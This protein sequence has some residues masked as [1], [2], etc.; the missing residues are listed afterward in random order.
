ML[1]CRG[2][3]LILLCGL[4]CGSLVCFVVCI[5][6]VLLYGVVFRELG[7][8]FGCLYFDCVRGVVSALW[9][10]IDLVL[11]LLG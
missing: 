7:F 3:Y 1:L 4:I 2:L 9:F 5:L 6:V 8:T 11:S 10:C